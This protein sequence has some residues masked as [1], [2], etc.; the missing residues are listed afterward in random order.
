MLRYADDSSSLPP[1][2]PPVYSED[3]SDG[4]YAEDSEYE[5]RCAADIA[6]STKVLESSDDIPL[7]VSVVR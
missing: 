1:S 3:D 5:E 2:D 7:L 6:S 4:D